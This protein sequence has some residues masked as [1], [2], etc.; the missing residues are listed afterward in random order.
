MA[1]KAVAKTPLG[2]RLTAVREAV[3]YSARLPFAQLLGMNPETL[4]GYER[5]DSIPDL[6]FL[7]MYKQRFSVNLDWLITGEGEMFSLPLAAASASE[8]KA[9]VDAA[10]IA[11]LHDRVVAIYLQV[12][13]TAPQRRITQEAVGLYNELLNSVRDVRDKEEVDAALPLLEYRL[14]KRLEQA[15]DAPGTGKRL[16]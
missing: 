12:K 14:R 10:F 15:R 1:R 3:G 5:G 4:G 13:Q 11:Q 9:G 7:A 8:E 16:A 6:D 2:Q